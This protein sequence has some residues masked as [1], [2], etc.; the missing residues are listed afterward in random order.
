MTP[1]RLFSWWPMAEV[2]EIKGFGQKEKHGNS[3][4][5]TVLLCG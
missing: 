1:W 3:I 5:I 2:P 4:K